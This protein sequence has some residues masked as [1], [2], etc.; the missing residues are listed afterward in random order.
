MLRQGNRAC[1]NIR[2]ALCG[3]HNHQQERSQDDNGK[4][5]TNNFCDSGSYLQCLHYISTSVF[6]LMDTCVKDT[7]ARMIKNTTAFVCPNA[8]WFLLIAVL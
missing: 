1:D 8:Y 2:A 3:V 7:I 6:L 5:H 4:N